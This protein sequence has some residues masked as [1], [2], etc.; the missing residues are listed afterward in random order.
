[1]HDQHDRAVADRRGEPRRQ[2]RRSTS[3]TSP[4]AR[5]YVALHA[6]PGQPDER[7]PPL[8]GRRPLRRRR[9]CSP[10]V[11][12]TITI[13]PVDGHRRPRSRRLPLRPAPDA[14][15]SAGASSRSLE[16]FDLIL[17][18]VLGDLVQQGVTQNDFSVTGLDPRRRHVR[19]ADGRRLVPR[20]PL[21]A[22]C[23]RCSRASR[24]IL[25][26]DGKP[27]ERNLQRNRITLR[28]ARR[29]GAPAADRLARRRRMGRARDERPDQLHPEVG[30]VDSRSAALSDRG[31]TSSELLTPARRARGGRGV[32]PAA[33]ARRGREPAA[34]RGSPLEER[35]VRG[36]GR[37][38]RGARARRRQVLR[39]AR[40]GGTPFVVVLFDARERASSPR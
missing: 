24:V 16:P 12:R 14:R 33:G 6:V 15:R 11:D 35:R 18:V 4:P 27:I 40:A 19:A 30:L 20:L 38:R 39:V 37:G 22:R 7:R 23:G 1:M 28:G 17:L 13:F 25:V 34:R 8:A 31:A 9:R 10:H 26:E 29:A 32:L 3:A 2:A 21:P 36:H 5:S